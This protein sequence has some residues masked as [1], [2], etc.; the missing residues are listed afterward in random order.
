MSRIHFTKIPQIVL[1][2]A[3]FTGA[4]HAASLVANPA[5]V[6][7][8]CDT[9]LG[10]NPVTVG[11]TLAAGATTGNVT[12]TATAGTAATSAVVLPSPAVL[13]VSSTTVATNF[14]FNMAAGC[15]GVTAATA[16]TL[17]FTLAGGATP[18]TVATT[19]GPGVHIDPARARLVEED[20]A[21]TA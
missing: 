21:A 20:L 6:T 9:V 8:T 4:G 18:L 1:A 7:L 12:V 14:T 17:T 11:I 16:L 5:T 15:K 2:L 10:P 13:S 3:V 19:M